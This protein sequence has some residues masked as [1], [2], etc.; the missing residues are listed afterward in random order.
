MEELTRNK[1][2]D[3]LIACKGNTCGKCR[4]SDDLGAADCYDAFSDVVR[5]LRDD[6][7][8]DLTEIEQLKSQL[9][10]VTAERDAALQKI[11]KLGHS[12]D[13]DSAE[14]HMGKCLGYQHSDYD[15]E[16]IEQCKNCTNQEGFEEDQP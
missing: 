11:N 15:D 16:P 7:N 6:H 9:A 2:I 4:L 5:S 14:K 8:A 10:L 1:T 13:C 3:A 12:V